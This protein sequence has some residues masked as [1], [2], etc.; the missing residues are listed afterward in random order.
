MRIAYIIFGENIVTNGIVK[1]Q[2]FDLFSKIS[3]HEMVVCNIT[4]YLYDE[5]DLNRIRNE[6]NLKLFVINEKATEDQINSLI[7]LV[8]H[9]K[10]GLLHA[11]SYYSA[12][13]ALHVKTREGTPFIFDLRGVM[14]LENYM[15]SKFIDNENYNQYI[16]DLDLEKKLVESADLNLVQT[17]EMADYVYDRY[18]KDTRIIPLSGRLQTIPQR[19]NEHLRLI[20]SGNIMTHWYSFDRLIEIFNSINSIIPSTL[21]IAVWLNTNQIDSF[22][23]I[24]D[25]LNKEKIEIVINSENIEELYRDHDIG[26]IPF[27][28]KFKESLY[29]AQSVK[30]AE[31]LC[32]GLYIIST[33]E[34]KWINNFI[35][36]NEQCGTIYNDKKIDKESLQYSVSLPRRLERVK[37]AE[38]CSLDRNSTITLYS[39]IY[40]SF[41]KRKQR[42][43]YVI[44]GENVLNSG[45][46]KTQVFYHLRRVISE[47]IVGETM[48][49]ILDSSKNGQVKLEQYYGINCLIYGKYNDH[50]GL[51][52]LKK[53]LENFDIIHSRS[54]YAAYY[55]S[56]L[57]KDSGKRI[58]FDVRGKLPEENFL[59]RSE[60]E[61]IDFDN[62]YK[63]DKMMEKFI[64]DNSTDA[65]VMNNY[66]KDYIKT[67]NEKITISIIPN[68]VEICKSI[69]LKNESLKV[70]YSGN[71]NSAWIDFD[72]LME[73]MKS[74]YSNNFTPV[75]VVYGLSSEEKD[76][77]TKILK[78]L[79]NDRFEFYLNLSQNI[80]SKILTECRFGL[81]PHKKHYERILDVSQ[82]LKYLDYMAYGILIISNGFVKEI[83]DYIEKTNFGFV[84]KGHFP[85]IDFKILPDRSIIKDYFQS[86]YGPRILNEKFNRLYNS[87]KTNTAYIIYNED[88]TRSGIIRTQVIPLLKELKNTL[89]INPIILNLI[90]DNYTLDEK[91]LSSIA[92]D[93]EVV[94]IRGFSSSMQEVSDI[95]KDK[96]VSIVHCRSYHSMKFVPEC[97]TIFFDT[98]GIL[99]LEE[100]VKLENNFRFSQSG[101]EIKELYELEKENCNNADEIICVNDLISNYYKEKYNVEKLST[102]ELFSYEKCSSA[103]KKEY[104]FENKTIL[105]FSGAIQT[106]WYSIETLLF[107][108]EQLLPLNPVLIIQNYI[109]EKSILERF[110][111][112]YCLAK[113]INNELIIVN[114]DI[115][116]SD[117]LSIS[118]IGLI[119]FNSQYRRSLYYASSTKLSEYVDNGLYIISTDDSKYIN[120]FILNNSTLGQVTINLRI[121]IDKVNLER[122]TRKSIFT[123]HSSLEKYVRLYRKYLNIDSD[124]NVEKK[125]S[126]EISN[127]YIDIN[128]DKS[129]FKVKKYI[130]YD[131][132][133]IE[134]AVN[135]FLKHQNEIIKEVKSEENDS[136]FDLFEE[137]SEDKETLFDLF[138]TIENS[139]GDKINNDSI[140]DL[141][142]SEVTITRSSDHVKTI[143]DQFE[144]SSEVDEDY[145]DNIFEGFDSEEKSDDNS[146]FKDKI[147]DLFE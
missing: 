90:P 62:Q 28:S 132:K 2:V 69:V 110:F 139:E 3:N 147:F 51:D 125:S 65:I 130:K 7:N 126:C 16:K 40:N 10:I 32:S 118:D 33:C 43:C 13:Y 52:N 140:F 12:V 106:P 71:L 66:F 19:E 101:K 115:S 108:F 138:E 6:Y 120:D 17:P 131:D 31:Y 117:L 11:R 46:I 113:S 143:F 94:I 134:E 88:I 38:Q 78:I 57:M 55:V 98:R 135:K 26:I 92:C 81:L 53:I 93:L 15:I 1:N 54:Y 42:L 76:Q 97:Y 73:W 83:N 22:N 142:E 79:F 123:F 146:N 30:F 37:I 5:S 60:M 116:Y 87:S 27:N 119:P 86:N 74:F 24:V 103:T 99:P 44:L 72:L 141:F 20:F 18:V 133:T 49:I 124:E 136:L 128:K 95:L 9:E 23:Q 48:L 82:P 85:E 129:D 104:G 34:S 80:Y 35:E 144:N 114:P 70:L 67:L 89:G 127:D 63:S 112:E 109:T 14:P 111:E 75:F 122:K 25:K 8:K 91:I 56:K 121:N 4:N 36:L 137:S 107:W 100:E 41:E 47:G 59:F 50:E 96:K 64:L 45:I 77:F 102:I 39:D 29:Y 145:L 105:L 21:T 58:I 61:K 68:N 84:V